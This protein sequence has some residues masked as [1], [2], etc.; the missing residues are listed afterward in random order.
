MRRARRAALGF[1]ILTSAACGGG[2]GSAGGTDAA[3]PASAALSR[4]ADCD[5]LLDAIRADARAK[6]RVQADELRVGG[7]SYA[8]GGGGP[9][10]PVA[11]STPAPD[12]GAPPEATDTNT[13]VPGV[14]EA[15]VVEV[16]GDRIYLLGN[17]D[18]S[19]L[20]AA[21]PEAATLAERVPIEGTPLGMFVA[22]GRALVVSS[23]FDDD[24]TLGGDRRC[25]TIGP[26]FPLPEPESF[27]PPIT[28]PCHSIFTKLTLLDVRATPARVVREA[29]IEGTY[30]AA[31]RHG[32]RGRMIVQRDWG[33][34][35]R[36]V[37]PWTVLPLGFGGGL[38]E[39][40][41][42]VDAWE[43][44]A[45]AAVDDSALAEWL[46]AVRERVG[47]TLVDRPL[48]CD[49]AEIPPT[50]G[51]PQG[52]TLIVGIDLA[53]DDA[54]LADTLLLGAA[55]EIY[56]SAETLVLAQP[57][58]QSE[59]LGEAATR[60]AL[61][62]F[63]LAPDA[64]EVVYRGSGFVP[65]TV[66]SQFSLDVRDDVV[67]VATSFP[68]TERGL[69]VTRVTTAA[70]RNGALETLGASEDLAPG[71]Q[72]QA[73]RFLGDRA[74]LVTFVR[75]D[76]LFVVDLA[77]PARPRM[78]GEVEL[79]G[80]SDYLHPLDADHLLT[81][82]RAGNAVG[83]IAGP[84]LRLF[85]VTDP[86]SPRLTSSF[87]LPENASSPAESDHLA[88]TFD[89]RRGLLAL[90]VNLYDGTSHP[91]LQ[92][93]TVDPTAGIA[94]RGVVDHGAPALVP[95]PPPYDFEGC[96]VFEAMERGVFI[97]DAV[98]SIATSEV[99]VHALDDL[100]EA[101]ATVPLP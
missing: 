45:L 90:P 96:T 21:P 31:R 75:I 40:L 68:H 49:R 58:W 93:F 16:A 79:P 10:T 56:A 51:A 82:G 72:L 54:P 94:L 85:D 36:L 67:R 61:H 11:M 17:D 89:A 50:G 48:A 9:P 42:R 18:L 88:F 47:Q 97:G 46:P 87:E 2:G 53:S 66:L 78:L 14:D 44:S 60:T 73:A 84:A 65:G 59:P 6:I 81:I 7:W 8:E 1:L 3:A 12:G 32:A 86:T 39:F 71:E 35:L 91:T 23:V 100:T 33:T 77:D 5:E 13:Q 27:F 74:Y 80:F 101:L 76:P 95:C 4:A 30:V 25:D 34:P 15:D 41:G 22:D 37:D 63:A 52:A 26:P 29:W 92:L 62:V 70:V 28:A 20:T 99:Q 98:Y 24:G 69:T 83:Q 43:S 64:A 38:A 55:T 19:I 57:V